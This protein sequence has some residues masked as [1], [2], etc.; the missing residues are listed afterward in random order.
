MEESLV[1]EI[2]RCDRKQQPLSIVMLDVD[3]FKRFNDSFG[4]AAGD[5]VLRELGQY[6]KDPCEVQRL[7]VAMAVKNLY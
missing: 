6:Y 3:R 1:R 5:A 2:Q 4:H 7:P